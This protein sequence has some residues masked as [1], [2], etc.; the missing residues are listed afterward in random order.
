[1]EYI[2]FLSHKL[3]KLFYL[4]EYNKLGFLPT[5]HELPFNQKLIKD[6]LSVK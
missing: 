5:G 4:T 2:S 3:Q 6:Y 1:M